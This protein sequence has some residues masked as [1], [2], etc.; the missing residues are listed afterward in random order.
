MSKYVFLAAM[1]L[2][3]GTQAQ[4]ASFIAKGETSFN[5][6]KDGA[7]CTIERNQ[8]KGNKVHVLYETTTR[9]RPM[10]MSLSAKIE[11][12]GEL[13]FIAYMKKA[14]T[15]ESI[16]V[17]DTRT[18]GW[19]RDLRIPCTTNVAFTEFADD[20]EIAIFA[21]L[22]HF[23]VTEADDGT[24]DFSKAKTVVG[25]CNGFWC[26]QTPGMFVNAKFS[27]KNLGYPEE[28]LKYYRGGMQAWTA[29]GLSVEGSKK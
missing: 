14:S 20:K 24:L 13:E 18:P 28:K 11:T 22:D 26:G 9:G 2:I 23:G 21:L 17:V 12:L 5:I 15:D 25:Y 16:F 10:P 27:L 8:T 3:G 1:I 4:A 7:T 19:H 6:E 29:L